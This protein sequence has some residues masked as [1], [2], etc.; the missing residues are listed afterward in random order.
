MPDYDY[1]QPDA[2]PEAVQRE[3]ETKYPAPA[4]SPGDLDWEQKYVAKREKVPGGIH[5][6]TPRTLGEATGSAAGLLAAPLSPVGQGVASVLG[7]AAGG[8]MEPQKGPFPLRFNYSYDPK[9][10]QFGR[11]QY[12]PGAQIPW[13][14][15]ERVLDALE[16]GGK[17]ALAVTGGHY[18]L[19]KV[20]EWT[21]RGFGKVR[22]LKE[23]AT[24]IGAGV[25]RMFNKYPLAMPQ[26]A[27]ELEE[28][29]GE[30]TLAKRT[31][32]KVGEV[33]DDIVHALG[34]FKPGRE[35]VKRHGL[36]GIETYIRGKRPKGISIDMPFV[37]RG[38]DGTPNI[39][40][41]PLGAADAI[42]HVVQLRA[43]AYSAAGDPVSGELSPFY[44]KAG[45]LGGDKITQALKAAGLDSLAED[46]SRANSDY[47]AAVALTDVFKNSR[48]PD[49]YI[50]QPEIRR[51]IAGVMEDLNRVYPDGRAR[52][53]R[54][55]IEPTG[56]AAIP[57]SEL[58]GHVGGG[59]SRFREWFTPPRP[60]YPEDPR[61]I[62]AT[63]RFLN[64]P[65]G[66]GL[67]AYPL[68]L[69]SQFWAPWLA[70]HQ[71]RRMEQEEQGEGGGQY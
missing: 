56:Q 38:A 70:Q 69:S 2:V 42:D 32:D 33:R 13:P 9:T 67:R 11:P 65:R 26:T 43:Q 29:I 48:R 60:Y 57:E 30:G 68:T 46:F 16:E 34:E 59:L 12:V 36:E 18:L 7:A 15:K 6:A 54:Q 45:H 4:P 20:P 62:A 44:R 31:G 55:A 23:T 40:Y 51:R 53:L 28:Q 61:M 22:M 14:T 21:A 64:S 35:R 10:Q 24:R 41:R 39:V 49:A 66:V 3:A 37:V 17:E 19:G 52:L 27:T 1:F 5:W 25:Y 47:G 8:Y 50:N 71:V 58:G 63:A